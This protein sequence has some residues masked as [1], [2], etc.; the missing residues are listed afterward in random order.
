[1]IGILQK[2][3]LTIS[4]VKG[5]PIENFNLASVYTQ[6]ANA[7]AHLEFAGSVRANGQEVFW[8][9]K[10]GNNNIDLP[11]SNQNGNSTND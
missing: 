5:E 8:S 9:F 11:P 2:G 4:D 10:F 7:V 3:Q 6:I 1:M